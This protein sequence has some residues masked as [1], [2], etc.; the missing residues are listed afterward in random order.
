MRT[1]LAALPDPPP[2]RPRG[3]YTFTRLTDAAAGAVFEWSAAAGVTLT[4]WQACVVSA[5]YAAHSGPLVATAG[6]AYPRGAFVPDVVV[7]EIVG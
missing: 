7:A 6:L 5:A 4:D 1:L 2:R 3:G